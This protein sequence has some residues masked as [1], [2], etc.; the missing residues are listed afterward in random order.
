MNRIEEV[1][2]MIEG[3]N[4]GNI[5]SLAHSEGYHASLK[6]NGLDVLAKQINQLYEPHD[7][8]SKLLTDE[9]IEEAED[10]FTPP[11]KEEWMQK[12][13]HH[14]W[15]INKIIKAQRDLTASIKDAECEVKLQEVEAALHRPRNS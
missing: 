2:G 1:K 6:E 3:F 4:E 14:Y 10:V 12:P 8:S 9:E 13:D 15:R 5:K 11:T 7:Q